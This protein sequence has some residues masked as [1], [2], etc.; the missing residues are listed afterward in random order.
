MS[1]TETA[2][3]ASGVIVLEAAALD[4]ADSD[5]VGCDGCDAEVVTALVAEDAGAD[6]ATAVVVEA[7][8]FGEPPPQPTARVAVSATAATAKTERDVCTGL[9]QL[10]MI[11]PKTRTTPTRLRA[12][13]PSGKAVIKR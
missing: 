2:L 6:D 11:H 13:R 4:G 8:G 7:V 3:A 5:A 12:R 10:A 1:R 9:L